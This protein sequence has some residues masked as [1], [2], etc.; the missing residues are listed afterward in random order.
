[1]ISLDCLTKYYGNFQALKKITLNISKGEF[2][3][4]LGPNGAGKTT[5]IKILTGLAK[6]SDGR[7]TIGGFDVVREPLKTKSIVG[8]IPDN[9]YLYEKLTGR[10]MLRLVG[11]IYKMNNVNIEKKSEGFFEMFGLSQYGNELIESYSHG[12]KQKLAIS[13]ALIHE[14]RVLVVDEPM[15]GLD[16][17]GAKIVRELFRGLSRNGTTIFMSTHIMEEAEKLC[18]RIGIIAKG[19]LVAGGTIKELWE[20]SNQKDGRLEEIF[21]ELTDTVTS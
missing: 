4:F 10:E 18:D 12:M 13:M 3:G 19:E 17:Q 1:M 5:T 20:K 8:Y 9:P 14:P 11:V 7:V 6:P 15:V 16:P 21:L 2:L